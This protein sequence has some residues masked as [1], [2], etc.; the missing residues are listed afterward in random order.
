MKYLFLILIL[1]VSLESFAGGNRCGLGSKIFGGKKGITSQT[2]ENSTNRVSS[3]GASISYGT[4][5]CKHDGNLFIDGFGMNGTEQL[6]YVDSNFEELI[7]QV[8]KGQGEYLDGL[9][10]VVGC[11]QTAYSSF[12]SMARKTY[13]SIS[14]QEV[15][16]VILLNETKRELRRDP[17]LKQ[18]CQNI[19]AG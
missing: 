13:Q 2:F 3:G 5:G 17:V 4:S 9:A 19:V 8:A 14:N 16:P 12:R 15:T 1:L 18:S 10:Y 7:I 6:E 11:P